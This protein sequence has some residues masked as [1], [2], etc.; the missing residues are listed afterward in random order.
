MESGTIKDPG[1]KMF[2]RFMS[3]FLELERRTG[4]E[5]LVRLDLTSRPDWLKE[6]G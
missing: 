5:D 1:R 4:K 2:K 3:G 6:L